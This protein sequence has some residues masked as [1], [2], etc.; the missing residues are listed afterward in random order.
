MTAFHATKREQEDQKIRR[1]E[2]RAVGESSIPSFLP[3]L[4][5]FLF[6][7]SLSC[8]YQPLYATPAGEA[9][10][11]HLA[12]NATASA[13]VAAEV[14]RGARET[15]AKEG[16]LA[17]GDGY[18]RLEIE[19]LRAD[20]TSE[21]VVAAQTVRGQEPSATASD[22]AVVVRGYVVRRAG[23][24]P[25]LDTGDLRDEAVAAAPLG[26]AAREIWQREDSLRA[27]GHRL[28]GRIVLRIL[29]HPVVTAPSEKP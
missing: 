17:P 20:E 13:V 18:P 4:L 8:G 22:L 29:G 25:D 23:A 16:A 9:Y 6:S 5:L 21:G 26:D 1:F 11:L 10:H 28:G 12:K 7:L 24:S 19:V 14:V 27:V 2:H 3:D 15:L